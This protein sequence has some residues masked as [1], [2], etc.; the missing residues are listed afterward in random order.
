MNTSRMHLKDSAT[1][2]IRNIYSRKLRSALTLIGIIIGILTIVCVMSIGEGLKKEVTKELESFGSDRMFVIPVNIEKKMA[3]GSFG[4]T[5]NG[6]LFE[7]DVDKISKIPGLQSITKMVYGRAS[8][9]FKEKKLGA[10]VY[11]TQADIFEQWEDMYKLETGRY[12]KDSEVKVA[13]LGND[14]ANEMF[15]KNKIAVGNYLLI[16]GERYRIVGILQKI[17]TTFSQ[18][19]DNSI[20]VPFDE[21]KKLFSNQL[22]KNEISFISI[23]LE[24]GYNAEEIKPIM[25]QE[26]AS[27]HRVT[28]DDKDFTVMTAELI[29]QTIG[30]ILNMVTAFLFMITL[31]SAIVGGVGI[32]NTM[33]TSVIERTKEIGILKAV[34]ATEGD[35]LRIF[36][37]ESGIIGFVGGMIGVILG[38]VLLLIANQFGVPILIKP[39]LVVFALSFAGIV[40]LVSG[41]FPAKQAAELDAVRALGFE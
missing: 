2:G 11:A 22:S 5:T 35:I 33:F 6:K 27:L 13:I 38:I 26:L 34:G 24:P 41:V 36:V 18:S 25:E 16:N 31:I 3:S 8:L 9:E 28:V 39:E 7:K 10:L 15:G 23:K 14:A 40:G 4:G 29:N 1:Y 32:A 37:V 21:G 12:F 30:T 17:G 19:D 20:F